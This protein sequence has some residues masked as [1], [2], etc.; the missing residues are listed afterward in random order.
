M[1][2]D[3]FSRPSSDRRKRG[4]RLESSRQWKHVCLCTHV[5]ANCRGTLLTVIHERLTD[6]DIKKHR[7]G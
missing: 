6:Q 1:M 7:P 2:M 4:L 3:A 5:E